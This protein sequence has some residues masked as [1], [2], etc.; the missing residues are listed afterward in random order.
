MK[1]LKNRFIITLAAFL[2]AL[3]FSIVPASAATNSAPEHTFDVYLNLDGIQGDSTVKNYEKWIQ[4]SSVQFNAANKGSSSSGSGA[5]AGKA[6]LESFT[7]TKSLDS[8]SIPLFLNTAAGKNISKGQIVFVSGTQQPTALLTIDLSSVQISSYEFSDAYET[9]TLS[10]GGIKMSYTPTTAKGTKGT[11]I[12][13]G[14]D[15]IKNM[16]Q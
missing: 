6:I 12:T 2:L 8:A 14:W 10:V 1:A 15:F 7:V 11:S 9:I 4:L 5:G 16:K 3:T 13:G